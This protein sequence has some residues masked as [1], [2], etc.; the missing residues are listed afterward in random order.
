M[1]G[2]ETPTPRVI[3][4]ALAATTLLV[5]ITSLVPIAGALALAGGV[6]VVLGTWRGSRALLGIGVTVQ[7]VAVIVA[8]LGALQVELVLA[9]SLALVLCWDLG[10]QAITVAAQVR[11]TGGETRPLVVHAAG[12]LIVGTISSIGIY[13]LYQLAGGGRPLLALVLLVGGGALVLAG[14]H[15]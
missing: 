8:A 9:A 12:T 11:P 6:G 13:S 15:L 7:F 2:T 4:P 5:V 14:T 3:A 10:E 1:T